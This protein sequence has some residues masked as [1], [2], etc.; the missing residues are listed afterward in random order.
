[1]I[2]APKMVGAGLSDGQPCTPLVIVDYIQLMV[3]AGQR[4]QNRNEDMSEL[5]RGLKAIAKEF[6]VPVLALSQLSRAVEARENKR[7]ML[8]DLRDSGSLEQDADV[9]AFIFREEYY[10]TRDEPVRR[11]NETQDGF[12]GRLADWQA[13]LDAVS[14]TAEIIFA[15]QRHG[16]QGTARLRFNAETTSFE[17][18]AQGFWAYSHGSAA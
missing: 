6:G 14:N 17:N 7:P 10:L 1:M 3:A 9:V 18:L 5:S 11:S 4:Q 12:G 15:K 2:Q 8:A 16:A 13:R